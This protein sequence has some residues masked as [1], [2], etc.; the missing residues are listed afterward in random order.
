M[1][2][3]SS[4]FKAKEEEFYEKL[5]NKFKEFI[6]IHTVIDENSTIPMAEFAGAFTGYCADEHTKYKKYFV[7][8]HRYI[9][10]IIFQLPLNPKYNIIKWGNYSD[11]PYHASG[12]FITGRRIINYNKIAE[13]ACVWGY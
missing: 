10:T 5:D 9:E 1:G 11:Y 12:F 2:S 6:A 4:T 7:W 13:N 3:S 8:C